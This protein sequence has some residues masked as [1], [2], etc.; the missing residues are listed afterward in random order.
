M[1]LASLALLV[2]VATA[3]TGGDI[4][5]DIFLEGNPAQELCR[6]PGTEPTPPSVPGTGISPTDPR[7]NPPPP[8]PPRNN[9]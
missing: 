8:P 2:G 9:R 5:E 6:A 1:I 4:C 7:V 3:Q